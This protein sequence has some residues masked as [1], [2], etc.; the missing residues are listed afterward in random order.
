MQAR[1]DEPNIGLKQMAASAKLDKV[2]IH[3]FIKIPST[4][5]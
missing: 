4:F 1:K 2:K 3:L 5:H